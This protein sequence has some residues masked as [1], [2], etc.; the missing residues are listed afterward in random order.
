MGR[1]MLLPVVLITITLAGSYCQ[2]WTPLVGG[3]NSRTG[4]RNPL[5][6]RSIPLTGGSIPLTGGS[7]PLTGGSIPPPSLADDTLV[8]RLL[9][10]KRRTGGLR[11]VD[12]NTELVTEHPPGSGRST[13]SGRKRKIS[14]N[15]SL[16]VPTTSSTT[17]LT[18]SNTPN[19]PEILNAIINIS[20][21]HLQA[22]DASQ[23]NTTLKYEDTPDRP[24][25]YGSTNHVPSP[26]FSESSEASSSSSIPSSLSPP[27][28]CS[29]QQQATT[30][31]NHNMSIQ[32]YHSQF[33]KEGLKMKVKQKIKEE[34]NMELGKLK[35][36]EIKKEDEDLTAEDE[37]RRR[38]RRNRNKVAAT[39]CRNK[40]KED[41]TANSRG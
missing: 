22:Y 14:L 2:E 6:V 32:R 8:N 3:R 39:K 36:E 16:A 35:V 31:L 28:N 4:G 20:S 40:K 23:T 13:M 25:E 10:E 12:R 7:I 38:R 34:P 18:G 29:Y 5:A 21:E 27:Y 26:T 1:A 15:C 24:P 11:Q 41:N 37:E 17:S 30:F 33:I 19:T 9:S